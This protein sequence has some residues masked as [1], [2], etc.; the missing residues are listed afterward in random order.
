[1]GGQAVVTIGGLSARQPLTNHNCVTFV[2]PN[3]PRSRCAE[4]LY[5]FPVYFLEWEIS[6][7]KDVHGEKL[8]NRGLGGGE[9]QQAE[10]Q[11]VVT[12]WL[13]AHA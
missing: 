13:K 11:R 6:E 7:K 12:D 5:P 8:W 1:M 4:C 2:H 10:R 9:K 3:D